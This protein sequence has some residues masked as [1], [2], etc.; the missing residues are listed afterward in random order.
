MFCENPE[1]EAA[2]SIM[3]TVQVA[4]AVVAAVVMTM[5]TMMTAVAVQMVVART[6]VIKNAMLMDALRL[7]QTVFENK[8]GIM[9]P[10][11]LLF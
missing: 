4:E 11:F 6:L 5:T 9:P 3:T 7:K 1:S 2:E 8:G 10:L